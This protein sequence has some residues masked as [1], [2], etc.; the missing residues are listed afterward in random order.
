LRVGLAAVAAPLLPA[1]LLALCT[2]A[3]REVRSATCFSSATSRGSGAGSTAAPEGSGGVDVTG[4]GLAGAAVLARRV[5][6]TL[7][8]T[9]LLAGPD[10]VALPAGTDVAAFFTVAFFAGA[11]LSGAVVGAAFVVG[12]LVAVVF[13]A[14]VVVAPAGLLVALG[15][16]GVAFSEATVAAV[17]L[18]GAVPRT[19]L[20]VLGFAGVEARGATAFTDG[21][22]PGPVC[23]A[24]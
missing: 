12:T 20:T 8:A 24:A 23:A 3:S 18:D 17:R 14:E 16:A 13:F 7:V 6:G 19:A 5:E 2:A 22:V 21:P 10:E 4:T 1:A 11:F 9:G 15:L